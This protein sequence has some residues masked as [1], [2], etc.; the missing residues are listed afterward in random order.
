MDDE[1]ILTNRERMKGIQDKK[2]NTDTEVEAY[3]WYLMDRRVAGF[4]AWEG[5]HWKEEMN[6]VYA[7][8]AEYS[9]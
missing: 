8:T 6:K 7:G 1:H 2:V 4:G 9:S 5:V 3:Q